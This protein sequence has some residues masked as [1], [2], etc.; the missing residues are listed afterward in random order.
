MPASAT[1]GHRRG[2]ARPRSPTPNVIPGACG[3]NGQVAAGPRGPVAHAH[4]LRQPAR[5]QT[6]RSLGITGA[7]R[8]GRLDRRRRRPQQRQLHPARRH[9][10]VRP[11]RRDY[12]DF[13]GD[14]PGQ[15]TSG[16]EAFLDANTIAGQ[17]IHV[18]D[19]QQLLR[20]ADSRPPATSGSRAWPPAP[21]WSASTSSARSR[22]PPSPT[23][24][25]AINYAVQTDHVNVIN[26]SFGSNPFPDVTAAGRDQAV[27]RRG[28]R[29]GRDGHGRP[30]ATPGSTNTIGSPST[31][32]NVIVGRRV[33]RLPVLRADQLRRGPV[34]RHHRLAERQHQL[35]QLRRLQTRPATR[36][37]WSRRAT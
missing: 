21:A 1:T 34:L 20:P 4:R 7:G 5:Q 19:V 13:T 12:Q 37:T 25:Q 33:D 23:S 14:G 32:P 26:E 9:V 17:G 36:S 10:G 22:T 30:P 18:Y 28:R 3:K 29:G 35:A 27:Q 11:R 8:Q 31:D 2:R 16:D 24:S 15:L 6:A